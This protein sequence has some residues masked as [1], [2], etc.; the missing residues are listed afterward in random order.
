[1]LSRV[2]M[3]LRAVDVIPVDG[4]DEWLLQPL[5]GEE[6]LVFPVITEGIDG[7]DRSAGLTGYDARITV[8]KLFLEKE[9]LHLVVLGYLD[10]GHQLRHRGFASILFNGYLAQTVVSGKISE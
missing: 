2:I 4:W 6:H 9:A 7:D 1:M 8:G 5:G 3:G 10:G